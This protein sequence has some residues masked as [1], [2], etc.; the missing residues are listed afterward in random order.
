LASSAPNQDFGP[1]VDKALAL[2]P[3]GGVIGLGSGQAASAFVRA[4]GQRV[5]QGLNV[6][7]VPT[8]DATASLAT[9]LG[10]PLTTLEEVEHLDLAVDGADEVAPNLDLIKG[11]GGALV[12]EKI[13]A[14]AAQRLIIL[15]GSEK[16]VPR[17]GAR[18]ILPVEVIPFGLTLCRRRLEALG[19]AS[20]PR[21]KNGSLLV[22]DNHNHILDCTVGVIDNP[23]QLEQ[24]IRVIPGVVDTGLFLGMAD[25]VFVQD[26]ATVTV[27]ARAKSST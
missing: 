15:V 19:L 27:R 6:R 1:A 7:A 5:R 24:S 13:V 14:A 25:T 22:T 18:G 8:S 4:L 12:R 17:L 16:L 20:R 3:D 26:G 11:L 23:V 10:I 2:L 21:H 9:E